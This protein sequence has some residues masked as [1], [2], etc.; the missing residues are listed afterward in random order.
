[1]EVFVHYQNKTTAI[2]LNNPKQT[3]PTVRNLF[4]E[5]KKVLNVQPKE[6]KLIFKG[7]TITS[8]ESKKK[9]SEYEISSG[10]RVLLIKAASEDKNKKLSKKRNKKT[11]DIPKPSI[12]QKGPPDGCM[13]G[14]KTQVNIFPNSPFIIYDT[15][16][17]VAK[18][19]IESEA[20]WIEPKDGEP[21]RIFLNDI[22]DKSIQP[23]NQDMDDS[24]NYNYLSISLMT[25]NGSKV[26]Y[27]IPKQYGNLFK[28]LLNDT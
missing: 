17:N 26:L 22:Q 13:E 9:L 8:K 18:L 12:I 5:I 24:V 11:L 2:K 15:N 3:N 10:S 19:S 7:K 1:M 20:L 27:F 21:E 4:S 16:G 25:S 23:Q 28:T 6:Q 14:L